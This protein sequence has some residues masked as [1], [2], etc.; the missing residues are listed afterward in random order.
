MRSHISNRKS[1]KNKI[2]KAEW[3]SGPLWGIASTLLFAGFLVIAFRW[4]DIRGSYLVDACSY[5]TTQGVIVLSRTE[6][7]GRSNNSTCFNIAYDY[8]VSGKDYRSSKINF[9]HSLSPNP[10]YAEG[11]VR[12]YPVGKNILVYYEEKNP[13]FAVLEPLNKDNSPLIAFCVCVLLAAICSIAAI[14]LTTNRR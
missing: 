14:V 13:S 5:R 7:C 8:S 4:A 1:P 11:Y 9:S 2:V 12:K 6:S 10:S 3:E